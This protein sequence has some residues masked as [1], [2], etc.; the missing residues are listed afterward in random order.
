V[1]LV[2]NNCDDIN[3]AWSKWKAAFLTAGDNWKHCSSVPS[4]LLISPRI[5]FMPSTW[6]SP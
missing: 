4:C 3:V 1:D 2:R 5:Y 6:R